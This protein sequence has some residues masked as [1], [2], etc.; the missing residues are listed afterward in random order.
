VEE[1]DKG[2]AEICRGSFFAGK[3]GK[4]INL[5]SNQGGKDERK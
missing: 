5:G 2:G 3:N 4:V 1:T